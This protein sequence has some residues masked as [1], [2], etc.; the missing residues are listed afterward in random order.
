MSRH[1]A[2]VGCA[3]VG[4]FGEVTGFS[5]REARMLAAAGRA[6][7]K[8]PA[9]KEEVLSGRLSMGAAAALLR[10][11]E[12]PGL[13]R[14]GDDW[15][16]WAATW[17]LG[18]LLEEIRK[19]RREAKEQEK[20]VVVHAVLTESG[21]EKLDRAQVLASRKAKRKLCV[22]ETV[23]ACVEHYLDA[24]DFERKEPGSRR[25]PDTTNGQPRR[26]I[27]AEE[28]RKI[29]EREGDRCIVPGCDHRIWLEMAH[30]DPHRFG[31]SR[32]ASNLHL[33]CREH[34][35]LYDARW[36]LAR[37]PAESPV[38]SNRFGHV[39][40]PPDGIGDRV[41]ASFRYETPP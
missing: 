8:R 27:P 36:L 34:H 16:V 2:V 32:E 12:R 31:G 37:G 22:G 33:P 7:A 21:K 15:L 9:L 18:R 19:R 6:V 13:M 30:I 38:F 14:P 10:I 5:G 1:F 28:R 25:M 39:F 26:N 23:E 20:A 35:V 4:H 40:G 41:R 29:L 24:H 17:P 3:S 11:L